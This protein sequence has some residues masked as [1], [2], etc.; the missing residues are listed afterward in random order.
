MGN[1]ILGLDLSLSD[2]ETKGIRSV[3]AEATEVALAHGYR[4]KLIGEVAADGTA[5]VGP[6]LVRIGDT[7]DVGG[8]LNAVRFHRELGGPVTHIGAGAGGVETAA[9]LLSD[10]IDLAKTTAP[11]QRVTA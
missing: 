5:R 2:V 1:E 11:T 7:L 8:A 3:T 6:R 10:I 4:I 9:A